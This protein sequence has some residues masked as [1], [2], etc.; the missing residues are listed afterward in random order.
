MTNNYLLIGAV[1]IALGLIIY[2]MFSSKKEETSKE[3]DEVQVLKDVLEADA[4][5]TTPTPEVQPEQP[6]VTEKAAAE[7]TERLSKIQSP[8]KDKP[9]AK[10]SSATATEV[11]EIEAIEA[12]EAP[13]KKKRYKKR[14]PKAPADGTTPTGPA[15]EKKD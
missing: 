5:A 14:K 8:D 2:W 11:K 15:P 4:K 3:T 12:A 1:L 10:M 9:F 6:V 13:K 7:L